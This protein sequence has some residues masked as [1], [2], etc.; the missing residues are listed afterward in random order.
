MPLLYFFGF[1]YSP[2]QYQIQHLV[3]ISN[4]SLTGG[5]TILLDFGG[6]NEHILN[7]LGARIFS[8]WATAGL[9]MSGSERTRVSV[10]AHGPQSVPR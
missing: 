8:E 7:M 4:N 9:E 10:W 1:A 2:I 3:I 6:V 5:L